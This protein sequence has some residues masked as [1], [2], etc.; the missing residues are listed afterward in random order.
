VFLDCGVEDGVVALESFGGD[1][2]GVCCLRAFN[3]YCLP[4]RCNYREEQSSH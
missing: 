2:H 1:G 4:G 3:E